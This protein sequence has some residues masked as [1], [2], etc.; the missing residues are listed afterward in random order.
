MEEFKG[1]YSKLLQIP[2]LCH[3]PWW[4]KPT[5]GNKRVHEQ[6]ETWERTWG[7]FF[8]NRSVPIIRVESYIECFPI[9]VSLDT[10]VHTATQVA[11]QLPIIVDT[12]LHIYTNVSKIQYL[13]SHTPLFIGSEVRPLLLKIAEPITTQVFHNFWG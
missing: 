1:S 4:K 12:I 2:M 11:F 6:R 5:I 7:P 9:A 13:G 8:C 3:Q 10:S